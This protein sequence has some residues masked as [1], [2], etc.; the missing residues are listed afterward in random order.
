[1]IAKQMILKVL[2]KN[3]IVSEK[4]PVDISTLHLMPGE[5]LDPVDAT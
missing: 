1:M 5:K 3:S 4:S 2:F